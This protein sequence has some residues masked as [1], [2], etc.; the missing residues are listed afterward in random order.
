MSDDQ[1][2]APRPATEEELA[3]LKAYVTLD[4]TATQEMRQRAWPLTVEVEEGRIIAP[5]P[6]D[7]ASWMLK[8]R[9]RNKH[10]RAVAEG[11]NDYAGSGW[12][13]SSRR[14]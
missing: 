3:I 10:Q 1:K 14:F 9:L 2:P 5:A 12:W 4:E 6:Y 8:T 7:D 13:R 11:D